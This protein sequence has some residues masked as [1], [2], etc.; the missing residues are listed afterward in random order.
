VRWDLEDQ[1]ESKRRETGSRRRTCSPERN[2]IAE[3]K[4]IRGFESSRTLRDVALRE[5]K[6]DY[7]SRSACNGVTY[8]AVVYQIGRIPNRS[9]LDNADVLT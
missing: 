6:S 2:E 5:T 7:I 1:R 8:F 9:L 3:T 4:E